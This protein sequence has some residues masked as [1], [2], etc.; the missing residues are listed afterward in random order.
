MQLGPHFHIT[1]ENVK[2][3]NSCDMCDA[4]KVTEVLKG[5]R[6]VISDQGFFF[7]SVHLSLMNSLGQ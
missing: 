7:E 2:Q 6:K 3:L 4:Q 1:S 5:N